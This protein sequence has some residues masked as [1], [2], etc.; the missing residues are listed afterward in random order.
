VTDHDA[1]V[2]AWYTERFNV[3]DLGYKCFD[4][5]LVG[6][7]PMI[8]GRDVLNA[9]CGYPL[10][11]VAM[12]PLARRWVAVD[13]TPEVIRRCLALVPGL[14][15]EWLLADLRALPLPD[16]SFDT[17]L[18]FSSGDHVATGRDRMR[19]EAFRV[20]R[21]GGYYVVAYANRTFFEDGREDV[22]GDFGY[23]K[24]QLP[25]ELI[26]EVSAAGFEVIYRNEASA[27]SGLVVR[28]P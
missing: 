2:R 19:A 27:R 21:P 14:A 4:W 10:D 7:A 20:L 25:E 18:D 1:A 11:E 12:A 22:P 6:M 13:F 5:H 28:K 16:Q 3:T 8:H 15:V 9:G 17:V 24:R 23:E 26:S